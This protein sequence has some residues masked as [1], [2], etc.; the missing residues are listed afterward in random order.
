MIHDIDP[1]RTARHRKDKFSTPALCKLL[2]NL[3]IQPCFNHACSTWYPNLNRKLKQKNQ[4]S[5][6]NCLTLVSKKW[7]NNSIEEVK[8]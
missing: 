7:L 5:Q 6:N 8:H 3:L 2:R 4:V 1:T